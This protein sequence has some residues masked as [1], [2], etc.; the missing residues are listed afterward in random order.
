MGVKV[1]MRHFNG[2]WYLFLYTK[3]KLPEAS[4]DYI[5]KHLDPREMYSGAT[6]LQ[7]PWWLAFRGKLL[8]QTM[9]E[10]GAK[11]FQTTITGLKGSRYRHNRGQTVVFDMLVGPEL[12]EL[13]LNAAREAAKT[14]EAS[15]WTAD[16]ESEVSPDVIVAIQAKISDYIDEVGVPNL[17]FY[18][19]PYDKLDDR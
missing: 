13:R 4:L 7:T 15:G 10:D 1:L 14:G 3:L 6:Q 19:H 8:I 17:A 2:G 12:A 9:K 16:I 11:G 5:E 18:K